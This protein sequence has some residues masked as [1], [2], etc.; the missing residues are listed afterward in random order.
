MLSKTGSLVEPE[1]RVI[2]LTRGVT[3]QML[4]ICLPLHPPELSLWAP[5]TQCLLMCVLG[6]R[7]QTFI[8]AWQTRY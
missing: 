2:D 1:D 3:Q 4:G 8:L 6:P 5:C 7:I